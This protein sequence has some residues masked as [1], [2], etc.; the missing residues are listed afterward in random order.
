ML[1][2][3]PAKHKLLLVLSDGAPCN[4]LG[5]Y[6]S[7]QPVIATEC[8]VAQARKTASVLGVAMNC[9]DEKV[10]SSMY[11]KDYITVSTADDMFVP[12]ADALKRIVKSW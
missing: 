5:G 7:M 1:K 8:A 12:I 11:G 3:H 10:Y 2:K 4:V 9:Y 6:D